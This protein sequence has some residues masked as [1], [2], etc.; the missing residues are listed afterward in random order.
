VT[1]ASIGSDSDGRVGVFA[2]TTNSTGTKNFR[3]FSK[4]AQSYLSTWTGSSRRLQINFASPTSVV[5]IDAIGAAA[6]SYGRLEVYSAAGQL[7]GRYTTAE[8]NSGGI[9]KMR[10]A[11]GT[12]DIAYAIAGGHTLG[13]VRL[14][15]LE[16][17][18]ETATLTGAHG[19][20]AFSALPAGTY[21]VQVASPNSSPISPA[22]GRQTAIVTANAATSDVDFGFVSNTS[23][24]QNATNRHDVNNSG[25]VSPLDAL[26]IINEL[27][28]RGSRVLTGTN[29]VP[30]P[31][32]DV[33]GD[34]SVSPLDVLLV[35]NYLNLRSG[36][37]EGEDA[38]A[39]PPAGLDSG[40]QNLGSSA[41]STLPPAAGESSKTCRAF[42]ASEFSPMEG[43]AG[44]GGW[45]D[46]L[47]KRLEDEANEDK[48]GPILELLTLNHFS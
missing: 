47:A 27:N 24:W 1:L 7:L 22:N 36:S 40:E 39:P 35:I 19:E 48:W 23:Q 11:R 5:E 43:F 12:A 45:P 41:S 25:D 4:A 44:Q 14:D 18:A 20:Y 32:I 2:D 21:R 30:P 33:S 46:L 6:A 17:G 31:F 37:G 10:I 13:T 42:A 15:N 3:G 8:L 34:S 16:F 29:F 38:M 26:L 28:L 9:E